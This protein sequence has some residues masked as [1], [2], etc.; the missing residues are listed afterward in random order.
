MVS[1]QPDAVEQLVY[2]LPNSNTVR[3]L[4][5]SKTL[6]HFVASTPVIFI[7]YRIRE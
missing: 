3:P 2:P 7:R 5:V 4:R 6:E 1:P